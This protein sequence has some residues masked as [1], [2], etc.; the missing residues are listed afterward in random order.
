MSEFKT[1]SGDVVFVL[2]CLWVCLYH[3]FDLSVCL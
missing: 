3:V 2:A 1:V